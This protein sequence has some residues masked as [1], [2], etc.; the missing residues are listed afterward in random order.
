MKKYDSVGLSI[1]VLVSIIIGA[2]L[3]IRV[4]YA[5]IQNY[6]SPF[7]EADL[8]AQPFTTPKTA[9]VVMVLISGLGYDDSLALELPVLEQLKRAGATAAVQSIPPTYS[10]TAWGTLITGAPPDTNDAPPIDKPPEELHL[11][12]IDTIF[13]RAHEAKLQTALLGLADWRRLIPRNQLDYT[14][15]VDEPGPKADQAII[16]ASLSLIENDNTDLV[17]I[18]FTQVDFAGQY[19]GGSSSEAYRQAAHTVNAYLGQ[20]SKVMDL[21]HSVLVVLADH[22]HIARGGHGGD[23]VEIIWQPLVMMGQGIISGNYSDVYQTDI[24]PTISTMLGLAPPT[25]AQGRI[26]FEMLQLTE[27]DQAI[28]Q[29]VLARQ[30]VALAEVYLTHIQDPQATLPEVLSA[31]LAQMQ[32][33]FANNNIS[34]ALQLALLAQEEADAQIAIARNSRLKAE[35]WPRLVIALLVILIWFT[36]MWRRRGFYA[37]SI[38]IAAIMTII[39]YHVL[40]R[41]Q[42]YSYSLSSLENFSELPFDITRRMTVSLLVGGGLVLIFLMLVNEAEWLTL[43]GTGYG[44]GV[45]VTFIFALPL[46]WAYWQNGVMATWRLPAVVPAFW[47]ITSLFEV[48]IAASLGLLLPW[49]I[50]GLNLL[51]NLVRRRFS[52]ARPQTES[53]TLPGLHLN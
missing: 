28:A 11:L 23:E 5:S 20:I 33:S 35:Q 15:F 51:V 4:F 9:K 10:Q 2:A 39:L 34:G 6:R 40:Y 41:L 8:S 36:T 42:G 30:R 29:L 26:L 13:A 44:F 48:T 1:L 31:D 21:G 27:S 52:K 49:P 12:E 25:A 43:L 38:V 7:R 24:A 3:W 45:L 16:E 47:Q 32:A 46:C 19:Q 17:L 14:F 18:H 37:G 53:D 50:M 22:G